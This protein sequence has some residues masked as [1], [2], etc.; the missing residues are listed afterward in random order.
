MIGGGGRGGLYRLPDVMEAEAFDFAFPG[1]RAPA[2]IGLWLEKT[3]VETE[4]AGED[5]RESGDEE[6]RSIW[7]EDKTDD[8]RNLDGTFE[9]EFV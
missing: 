9:W 7:V 1:G 4:R 8:S 2:R 5:S 3:D 6:R